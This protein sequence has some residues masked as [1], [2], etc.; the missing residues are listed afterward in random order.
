M[1]AVAAAI[2]ALIRLRVATG[3]N[4]LTRNSAV[5]EP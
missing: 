3:I 1:L 4:T 2:G 5:A